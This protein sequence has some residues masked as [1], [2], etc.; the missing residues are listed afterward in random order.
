MSGK[1]SLLNNVYFLGGFAT[2][3]GMLF[4]FDISSMSGVVG[5]E[6]YQEYF[7]HPSS[8]LQGGIV[9]A[10]AAGS[11]LGALMAGSLGD[12]ISRKRTIMLAACIW[13]VGSIIQ[14]ASVNAG[15][16]IVGR[17]INGVAVGLASM[18]VPVYQ[19]EIAPKNIRG[20]IVSLQ[21][22]AITW[23]IL[24]QYFIQYG[25]SFIQ[26]N[27]AFRIPWGIQ[28]VPGLILLAGI[29]VFPYS[30]RWLADQDRPEEALEVLANLRAN[31]NKND[32]AVLAEFKEIQDAITF[33]RTLAARSYAELFRYPNAKRVFLGMTLQSWSQ[34]TGMNV[35]MY[36][37]VFIFQGAGI[38]G[39]NANLQASSIQ[40]V[41]NVVMTIPA[42]L[43]IDKWGRRPVLL[44]GST[45]MALWLFLIGGLMGRFGSAT[46]FDGNSTTTWAISN[47]SSASH[48]VIACSY[49]FVCSFAISWGPVSWTYPAE[50]YPLRIRS[51]AVS[52]STASNWAFNFI[53]AYAVPPALQNIQYRTY[54]IFGG[55]C[56]AMTIH[57]FFMFPETKGR[58]LEEMDELFNS[59]IP[60]WKTR[61]LPASKLEH[62]IE[63]IK[64][65]QAD[66]KAEVK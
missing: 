52:L 65:S 51:K 56:V 60:A 46:S 4:G 5:T 39:Q 66:E 40:Y 43:F 6:R 34:L 55:F 38:T 29:S 2:M 45:F 48:A 53:L 33:D 63:E 28:V 24:I 50:I 61:A 12:R 17:I 23:G 18:I 62:D 9:A 15:M 58:T 14:C 3:G 37:I 16:L 42:I 36:Y 21:Q 54:Y 32:P 19:S 1:Y 20:R 64:A 41:L 57:V 35:A 49:L 47:N 7:K 10:M 31:G 44:V 13:I 27:A 8:S 22:W 30:P 25:C 11:F 59:D 26:S